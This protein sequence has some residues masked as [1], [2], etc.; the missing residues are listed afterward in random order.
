MTVEA[1]HS[2]WA[3][4]SARSPGGCCSITDTG[5]R[6]TWSTTSSSAPRRRSASRRRWP[7]A[8]VPWPSIAP[9]SP[10]AGAALMRH[11]PL[12]LALALPFANAAAQGHTEARLGGVSVLTHRNLLDPTGTGT[13]TGSLRGA[14][15]VLAGSRAS[16]CGPASSAA[17]S[18]RSRAHRPPGPSHWVTSA[19]CWG[20]GPSPSSSD[21]AGGTPPTSL[22]VLESN[23][24]ASDFGQHS[25]GLE[26][27]HGGAGG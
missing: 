11:L 27:L 1:V 18:H 8:T 7:P 6:A 26:W 10:L 24:V 16:D 12:I 19:C 25:A 3:S 2:R 9:S 4:G 17:T 5:C 20:P 23:T 21:T 22:T 15:L 13:A 14:E